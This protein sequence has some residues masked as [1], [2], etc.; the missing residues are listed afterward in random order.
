MFWVSFT[1][2]K[3]KCVG[4]DLVI[5]FSSDPAV[6][7]QTL[8]SL[9]LSLDHYNMIAKFGFDGRVSVNGVRYSRCGQSKSSI[10]KWTHHGPPCHPPER[11]LRFI[12]TLHPPFLTVHI[13]KIVKKSVK[14]EG[15][16]F[17]IFRWTHF[18]LEF[19]NIEIWPEVGP[20]SQLC[21]YWVRERNINVPASFHCLFFSDPRLRDKNYSNGK[22]S[23]LSGIDETVWGGCI[24]SFL[25]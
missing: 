22:S 6:F 9:F 5:L 16:V 13:S 12:F 23:I 15:G 4:G 17:I 3:I 1:V 7:T 14:M 25:A 21:F 20:K 24:S 10:L 19:I 2:T 8:F 18:L 11:T